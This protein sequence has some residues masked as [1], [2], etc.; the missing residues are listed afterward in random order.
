MKRKERERDRREGKG[1]RSKGKSHKKD[2]KL[3]LPLFKGKV[4]DSRGKRER[5]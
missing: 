3:H 5:G 1:E 4:A 2:A